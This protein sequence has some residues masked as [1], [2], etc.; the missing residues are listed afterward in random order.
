VVTNATPFQQLLADRLQ[1][2]FSPL[3]LFVGWQKGIWPVKIL[4]QIFLKFRIWQIFGI[5]P[6]LECLRK[7]RLFK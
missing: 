5:Q 3:T 7:N 4:Y 6:K 2:S 1:Y